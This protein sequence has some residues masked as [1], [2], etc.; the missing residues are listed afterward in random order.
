MKRIL[1]IVLVYAAL[2]VGAAILFRRARHSYAGPRRHFLVTQGGA[3]L[4]PTAAEI[5]DGVIS[6]LMGGVALDLREVEL[7]ERPARLDVLAVMG[8]VE[9]L[10][11]DEWNVQVEIETGMGGVQDRRRVPESA[12]PVDLVLSGR[13]VMAGLDI[14]NEPVARTG[15]S[16]T[17]RAPV[18][19][20][21]PRAGV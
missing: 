21:R 13:L 3:D 12:G 9:I 14:G 15:H 4:R 5:R 11:P 19:G 7:L 2:N 16:R 6:V 18:G 8:G 20:G 1:A 17:G 10:V